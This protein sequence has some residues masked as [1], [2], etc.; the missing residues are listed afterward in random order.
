M[1]L[2]GVFFY[3]FGRMLCDVLRKSLAI[4]GEVYAPVDEVVTT[5]FPTKHAI[6]VK[7][8][9]GDDN[10]INYLGPTSKK[11]EKK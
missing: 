11:Y 5:V 4:I 1:V 8:H 2:F 7:S 10:R 6:G 3:L 9:N